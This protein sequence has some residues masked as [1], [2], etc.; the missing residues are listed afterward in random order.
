MRIEVWIDGELAQTIPDWYSRLVFEGDDPL[1]QFEDQI[2]H[3]EVGDELDIGEGWIL[4][5]TA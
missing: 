5:R 3:M 2:V 4:K 1:E